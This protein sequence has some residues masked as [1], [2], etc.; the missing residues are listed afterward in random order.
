[1]S[2]NFSNMHNNSNM[3]KNALGIEQNNMNLNQP[4]SNLD[5][6]SRP[7]LPPLK[8]PGS[9]SSSMTNGLEEKPFYD[10]KTSKTHTSNFKLLANETRLNELESKLLI[11]E[12]NQFQLINQLKNSEFKNEIMNNDHKFFKNNE[13]NRQERIEKIIE[14]MKDQSLVEKNE[15][16]SKINLIEE[17]LS[18]EEKFKQEQRERDLE[19]YK[20]MI[21]SITDKVSETVKLEID[22]RF[23][24]DLENKVITQNMAQRFISEIDDV[25]TKIE[26][27]ESQNTIKHKENGKE[28]SERANALSKYV[29]SQILE[30]SGG[31]SKS[32]NNLKTI[33]SKL[34]EEIKNSIKN[35]D[36]INESL[37]FQLNRLSVEQAK[38]NQELLE[39]MQETED[40]INGKLKEY[41]EYNE[42]IIIS[43]NKALQD[44]L[45][46]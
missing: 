24:A 37:E 42:A 4:I 31:N 23:K 40:R 14:L 9:R 5:E 7:F 25:K 13:E 11:M 12:Q 22:A 38:K 20:T 3:F 26:V 32:L 41:K 43:K 46:Y 44:K 15:L 16:K 17:I 1:M 28:C 36:N 29:D 34:T 30:Y 2:N 35:Q 18:R 33:I 10:S 39:Q 8:K 27:F 19:L 21:N 45:N 6:N